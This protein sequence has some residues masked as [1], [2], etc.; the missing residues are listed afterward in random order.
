[1]G[2][3][4]EQL[5][6]L[7]YEASLDNSLWPELILELT[8]QLQLAGHGQYIEPD[9]VDSLG[10]LAQHFRRAFAISE[11]MV[12]LQEREAH[13]GA[14]LN[15]F[16]FGLALL[17]DAGQVI[18]SNRAISESLPAL[19]VNDVPLMLNGPDLPEPTPLVKWV[20]VCNLNEAPRALILDDDPDTNLLMLPRREAVRM[21][22]PAQA[23]AVL[24]S[25]GSSSSD[26]LRAFALTHDLTRRATELT[27]A[28]ARLGDLKAAAE[29]LGVTY[30]SARSYL[31]RVY[32]KTGC[33]GQ[34]ELVNELARTPMGILRAR[35]QTGEEALNV[36]RLITLRDGRRMEFFVL[37]PE[38]GTPVVMFD[39]LSGVTIDVLG[40]PQRCLTYLDKHNIRLITP[41]RPGGFRSD[42]KQLKSLREFAPDIEEML[43]HLGVDR[44]S[45]MSVSFGSGS[46]LAVA[47]ELQHRVDR[48]LMSAAAYPLY[49]HDNWRELDQFYHMSS[50]LGRYWPSMLRQIIPFLVR[51]I[52]QNR[53]RYF[54]RYCKRTRSQHDIDILSRPI[55]R[56]RT[57]EMLA[58]RTAAGMDGMVE[59][60]LLNAQGWDFS[61]ADINVPVEL[62]HGVLD[63]VAPVQGAEALA[64]DLPQ[65][66]MYRLEGKGHYHHIAGWPALVAR[67]AGHDVDIEGEMYDFPTEI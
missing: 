2:N 59:E 21:G 23:A 35:E 48:I 37:G 18:L 46:A 64:A 63:N 60:N 67:A 28:I 27:G 61:V 4:A 33:R 41:C 49:R 14:V 36:R 66:T 20:E 43:E 39:A 31:K 34:V 6:H 52:M 32:E 10:D 51:S 13:M 55:V 58:E 29:H 53:D 7:V 42:S 12:G 65:A 38:D 44:F 16:S 57:A 45:I 11:K 50:I 25:T 17:D 8:E 40:Y 47:H 9:G 3:K 19:A 62:A 30:E 24:I 15:T 5:T 54:D 22:F 1:M 56:R 26:G